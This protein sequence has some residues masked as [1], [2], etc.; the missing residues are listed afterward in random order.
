[1]GERGAATRRRP[2]RRPSPMSAPVD[3]GNA[4]DWRSLTSL[5]GKPGF[6]AH[7]SHFRE[8]W[9]EATAAWEG[10]LAACLRRTA[11]V[12][13]K[14]EAVAGRRVRPALELL[15]ERGFAPVAALR[16]RYDANLYHTLYR[17]QLRR[18]TLD[19]IRLYTR[20]AAG[21]PALLAAFADLSP[22][23]AV[24]ASVRLKSMK[25]H[26][27]VA[28]RS[29]GDLRSLLRSPNSII[30]F[31]HSADEPADIVREV[32]IFLAAGQRR[33]FLEAVRAAD[34][35]AGGSRLRR[36]L[37]RLERSVPEHDIDPRAA[38]HRLR[39]IAMSGC[40]PPVTA[41]GSQAAVAMLD[42]CSRP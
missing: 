20:W 38:G 1:V 6:Y 31:L 10:E 13:F 14:V 30:N 34:A 16:V 15:A 35:D 42:A 36:L 22:L 28:R 25:G 39:A 21:Q 4:I 18:A 11:L 5:P 29:G 8:G 41:P 37:T 40:G 24:P 26:A 27:L 33:G 32:P 7:D 12:L 3:H 9:L 23:P 2:Q 17:Y 19:K